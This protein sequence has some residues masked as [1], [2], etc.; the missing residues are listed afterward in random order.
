MM[1]HFKEFPIS[2]RKVEHPHPL[3]VLI[4]SVRPRYQLVFIRN[5]QIFFHKF[6][7][8]TIIYFRHIFI[9]TI[10]YKTETY[11]MMHVVHVLT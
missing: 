8:P 10:V 9:H 1:Q 5:E 11:H 4:N 6:V 7:R 3:N 2:L